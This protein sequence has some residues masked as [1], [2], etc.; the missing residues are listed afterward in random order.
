MISYDRRRYRFPVSVEYAK[1]GFLRR[2][3]T[4]L[5]C[6]E[7][8]FELLPPN[9]DDE[10]PERNVR[11]D[12]TINIEAFVFNVFGA[13]DNLAWIWVSEIQLTKSDGSA[14]PNGWVGLGPKNEYVRKSLPQ[15]LQIYLSSRDVWFQH[16][17]NFR[18]ALAHRIPLYIPP[19]IVS[20]ERE[21]EWRSL[22]R[23][24]DDAMLRGDA[25]AEAQLKESQNKLCRFRPWMIHSFSEGSRPVAFHA[26]LI[27]D[28]K[29]LEELAL[30]ILPEL[31]DI[32]S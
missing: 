9:R 28:F 12:A 21:E 1:H 4:L 18:H 24:I 14:I 25:E 10:P 16:L 26:Q 23:A 17:E 27:A 19:Y 30:K 8:T 20:P 29:T 13:I 31:P 15:T 11:I 22:E 32:S 2:L 5:R 6:I 7:N 3:G